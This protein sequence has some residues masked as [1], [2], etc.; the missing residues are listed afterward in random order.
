MITTGQENEMKTTSSP[1]LKGNTKKML[2]A[3]NDEELEG[4]LEDDTRTIL[5]AG[6]GRR[7]RC[8]ADWNRPRSGCCDCWP[9][10]DHPRHK[11]ERHPKRETVEAK[12][13]RAPASKRKSEK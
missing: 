13:V 11:T 2:D 12:P 6:S 5:F 1:L 7:S 3:L 9:G 4:M 8:H 10:A